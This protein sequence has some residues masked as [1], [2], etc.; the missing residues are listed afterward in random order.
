MENGQIHVDHQKSQ[1]QST[2][3]VRLRRSLNVWLF[4]FCDTNLCKSIGFVNNKPS[5][6]NSIWKVFATAITA[7]T[8]PALTVRVKVYHKYT[9][10]ARK[11]WVVYDF[12]SGHLRWFAASYSIYCGN[13]RRYFC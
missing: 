11:Y 6:I 5:R 13:R 10:T 1:I 7:V 12:D 9:R 3:P 8:V 2:V 4:T